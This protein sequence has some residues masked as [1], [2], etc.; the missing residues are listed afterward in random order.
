ME[1]LKSRVPLLPGKDSADDREQRELEE[2]KRIE[3]DNK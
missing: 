3:E 2:I 1:D